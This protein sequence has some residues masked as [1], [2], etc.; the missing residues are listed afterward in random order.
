MP[1]KGM[2][3]ATFFNEAITFFGVRG[4]RNSATKPLEIGTKD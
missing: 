3:T 4:Y 1:L 2:K